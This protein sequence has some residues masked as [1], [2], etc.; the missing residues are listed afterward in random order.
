MSTSPAPRTTLFGWALFCALLFGGG[1]FSAAAGA[2]E[3]S[4]LTWWPLVDYR[5]SP[6]ADYSSLHLLGPLFKYERK[7][8]EV[9][10]GVRPLFFHARDRDSQRHF[11][12][13]L[14]PLSS[15]QGEEGKKRYHVLHLLEYDFGQRAEGSDN[16]FM[17]FPFLFYG[18]TEDRGD[19]FAFFPFGG[20]IYRRFWRDEI[21]FVL[22]PGYSRTLKKGTRTTNILWPIYARIEGENEHGTK[23]WP[24][25]G[26][27][28]KTGVYRKRF[29]LWPFYFNE[30]LRLDGDNPEHREVYFPFY[31]KHDSPARTR[32]TWLWPFFSHVV[33]R[34]KDYEEWNTPWPLIRRA[35][36]SYKE[37][38]KYLPLYSYERTGSLERTWYLWP[39]YLRSRLT[40]EELIQERHRILYFLF[41][42]QEERLRLEGEEYVKKKWIAL[43]PLFAYERRTGVSTFSALALIEPFFPENEGFRRNWSPLWTL[44][45]TRW[46]NEGNEISTFLWNLYWKERRGEDLAFEV[47]PLVRY[48]RVQG[49]VRE[50]KLLKGL[51]RFSARAEEKKLSLF[52]LPWGIS[53]GDGAKGS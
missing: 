1:A 3:D 16:E 52:Y 18:E 26:Y 6:A 7:G 32:R 15:R 22:F 23:L 46:D 10:Y 53:W 30:H 47:F 38:R 45:K 41:A 11:S 21:R 28:E 8:A 25:Y 24:L 51:I 14:Y 29:V 20:K 49:E 33:D 37:S 9:E 31:I 50:F 27:A 42:N 34:E 13:Y 36:G 35:S 43:W 17:L 4:L 12:E 44:Y 48:R 5:H 2:D 39:I 19:Y 40:T